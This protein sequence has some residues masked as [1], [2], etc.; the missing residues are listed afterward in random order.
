[1]NI[2]IGTRWVLWEWWD[3]PKLNTL[4]DLTGIVA[5]MSVNQVRGRAIR[6]DL[7]NLKKTS[8][9]YDIV[10][11]WQGMK[12]NIDVERLLSK[13]DKFYG[14]DDSWLIIKWANHIYPDLKENYIHYE[15]INQNMLK[16]VTLRDYIYDLWGINGTFSNKEIFWLNLHVENYGQ[17]LPIQELWIYNK[18]WLIKYFKNYHLISNFWD[19]EFYNNFLLKFLNDFINWLLKTL[20]DNNIIPKDFI[21]KIICN[22]TSD[23]KI[24]SY[25]YDELI[26]KSFITY[27]SKVFSII[28]TQKYFLDISFLNYDWVDIM[29]K[30]YCFWLWD[31]LCKNKNF[32]ENLMKNIKNNNTQYFTD[33]INIVPN[34]FLNTYQFMINFKSFQKILKYKKY[35]TNIKLVCLNSDEVNKKDYVGKKPFITSK[36]E[37][38]W[39]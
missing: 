19:Q 24:V 20:Q 15:K 30:K 28:S 25:Y 32:R 34:I 21:F 3:C 37:K 36:I 18:I 38:L 12:G 1:M 23:I 35:E 8:N 9:V 14:I 29:L 6:L 5:Y 11:V 22:N 4:I 26:I 10:C 2:L 17:I 7:E 33:F 13:H 27:V 16:R 39:I 31:E